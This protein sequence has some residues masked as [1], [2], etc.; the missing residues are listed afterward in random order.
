[1]SDTYCTKCY[2]VE[3][4]YPFGFCK[5]CWTKAG[6]PSAMNGNSIAKRSD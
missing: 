4:V 2:T 5:G 6:K 1:M 3:E